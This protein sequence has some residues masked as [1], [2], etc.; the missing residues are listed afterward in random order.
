MKETLY[1]LYRR[2]GGP[3]DLSG[4]VQEISPPP[5]A[6]NR[7]VKP[8]DSL[9]IAHNIPAVCNWLM[10]HKMLL[11]YENM[12]SGACRTHY[13]PVAFILK[14]DISEEIYKARFES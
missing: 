14:S 1:P 5:R 8:V 10:H 4:L 2:L 13:I 3:R 9:Y 11:W 6:E 12:I 7:T